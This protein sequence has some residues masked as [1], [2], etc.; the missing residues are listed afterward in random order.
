MYANEYDILKFF[1]L[2]EVYRSFK[3]KQNT[4]FVR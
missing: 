2:K 3:S 4:V 1:L